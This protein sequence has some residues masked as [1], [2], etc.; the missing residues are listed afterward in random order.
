VFNQNPYYSEAQTPGCAYD[1]M[2]SDRESLSTGEVTR[3]VAQ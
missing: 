3:T 2:L 1:R